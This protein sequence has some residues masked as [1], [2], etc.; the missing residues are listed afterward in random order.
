MK[1]AFTIATANFL[2]Q[3]KTVGDSFLAHHPGDKFCIVLLDKLGSGFDKSF[4]GSIE[5]IEI[6]KIGIKYFQ[7]MADRY[8]IFELSNSLKPFCAEFFLDHY[9][10]LSVLV[11]LDS[12]VFIYHNM[13]ELETLLNKYNIIIS[14]HFFTPL[15]ADGIKQN[16]RHFLNSG[17]YNGGFFAISKNHEASR[18][19]SWWKERMR[20]LC[21][22][23]VAKGLFVDQI[24]LNYVPLY[25]KGV[26]LIENPGFNVAY[27]NLHEREIS[28]KDDQ[29]IV[30]DSAPLVF[31][32]FSGYNIERAEILAKYQHRYTFDNRKELA[33]LF[34]SY[35]NMLI[36]N[37]YTELSQLTCAY[38]KDKQKLNGKAKQKSKVST[39]YKRIRNSLRTLTT[40]IKTRA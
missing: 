22:V 12:D 7:E 9:A 33:P 16:E 40:G 31:F 27:W 1:V 32:H 30:N 28:R 38:N 23:D 37:R 18:F 21:F 6:E 24:W 13:N 17:L 36:T 19:L 10:N 3:A 8:S 20:T 15:P 35:R 4:F 34:E 25:F 39:L 11:Y 5:V 26:H 2:S 29:Y 14:P